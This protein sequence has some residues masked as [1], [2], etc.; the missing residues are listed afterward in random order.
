MGDKDLKFLLKHRF[1]ENGKVV[2]KNMT[3]DEF[4][5]GVESGKI[6]LTENVAEK[7]Y[8]DLIRVIKGINE[9]IDRRNK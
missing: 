3:I 7:L 1:L 8:K 2:E 5:K 6:K 4:R 9:E